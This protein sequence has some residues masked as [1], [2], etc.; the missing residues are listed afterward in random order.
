MV[1]VRHGTTYLLLGAAAW[2]AFFKSGVDPVVVGLVMGLLALVYPATRSDLER[3]LR[4]SG[5]SASS[6]PR[7]WPGAHVP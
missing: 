7:N 6:R 3:T 4:R 2:V 5:C 1:G